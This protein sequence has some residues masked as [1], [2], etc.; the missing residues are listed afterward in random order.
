VPG[1]VVNNPDSR[2][3]FA[4]WQF[5]VK[6]RIAAGN[7]EHGNYI[8]TAFFQMSL[9]TGQ[10]EQGALNPIITPTIAYGKG[11]GNFDVQGTLGISLP[12]GNEALIGR[13]LTWNDT[14]QYRVFKKIWP[15]MEVNFTHFYQGEHGGNTSVYLTPGVV[16]GKFHL[17]NRLGFTV[18]GGYEIAA[19][20]F[21]PTNHIGIFSVR[22]PF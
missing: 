2:N 15:E 11:F 10:F 1:Y 22:F 6:Y 18:G 16:L 8:L 21:H 13:N 14:L 12:T 5:L 3:G 9:P 4:D 7:E 19:T 17:W 20:S